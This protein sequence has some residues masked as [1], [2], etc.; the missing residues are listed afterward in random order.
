MAMTRKVKVNVHEARENFSKLVARVS[1]GEEIII[2][3][4]G[5]PVARLVPVEKQMKLRFPGS[6]KGKIV[7][8]KDFDD[9]SA[10]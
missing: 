5:T 6:A 7:I 4:A 2:A 3:K 1:R 9:E 10:S 8:G